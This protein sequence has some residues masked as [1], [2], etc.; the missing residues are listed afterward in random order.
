MIPDVV[1]YR[2]ERVKTIIISRMLVCPYSTKFDKSKFYPVKP[3]LKE[4]IL[5][6]S[7]TN[8]IEWQCKIYNNYLDGEAL[9][10]SSSIG[11]VFHIVQSLKF[12]I[13]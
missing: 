2:L 4:K 13:N 3:I 11:I 1:R 10:L 7:Q 8:Y 12:K 6:N 5:Q 9:P